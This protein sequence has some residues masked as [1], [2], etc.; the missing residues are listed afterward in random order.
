M[1]AKPTQPDDHAWETE[2]GPRV[3]R[4]YFYT[5]VIVFVAWLA[6]LGYH[7]ARRWFGLMQ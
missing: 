5:T 4:Q 3:S 1:P 7:A 6:F 2:L